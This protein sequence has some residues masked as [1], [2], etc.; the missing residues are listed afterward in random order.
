MSAIRQRNSALV[1]GD[2]IDRADLYGRLSAAGENEP[3]CGRR[4]PVLVATPLID[5]GVDMGRRGRKRQLDV[6]SRYWELL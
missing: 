6:E 2:G 1:V 3:R 5:E 4:V